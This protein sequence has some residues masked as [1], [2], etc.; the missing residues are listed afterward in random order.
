MKGKSSQQNVRL[1]MNTG[2]NEMMRP[3]NADEVAV[4]SLTFNTIILFIVTKL[5]T[6]S[7]QKRAKKDYKIDTG[8]DGSLIPLNIFKILFPRSII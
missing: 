6:S 8:S 5:D 3:T 2:R 1:M 7:T 4:E